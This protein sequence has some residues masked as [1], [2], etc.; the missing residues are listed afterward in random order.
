[1]NAILRNTVC[2]IVVTLGLASTLRAENPID[3]WFSPNS[4]LH[5]R[6]LYGLGRLPL[7][8]YFALHPPVYYGIRYTRPYGASPFASAPQL[9]SPQGYAAVPWPTEIPGTPPSR[10]THP[11]TPPAKTARTTDRSR[12]IINPYYQPA[13]K[14]AAE[15]PNPVTRPA[16]VQPRAQLDS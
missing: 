8:P 5:S 2:G 13:E 3:R 16:A 15:S 7:P 9:Q 11:H 1:M 14:S 4:L 6:S 10:Q 12:V